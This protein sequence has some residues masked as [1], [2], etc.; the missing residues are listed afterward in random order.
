MPTYSEMVGLFGYKSKNGVYG[1]VLKLV[2]EGLITKDKL[3]RIMPTKL[4]AET[5]VLGLIKAGF[6][7]PAEEELQ[8]TMSLDDFMIEKK[9]STYI[10]EVDGDSMIDAC[11]AK[12]DMVI[13]Q[14]TDKAKDGQIVIAEIDGEFTMKFFRKKGNR[15]WLEAAN[16]KYPPMYPENDLKITAVVKGIIRKY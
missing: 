9:E 3:G 15:V 16:K 7:S 5:K 4:F 6:P 2:K 13:A 12:G 1:L 8:D 14:R 10:L 11:I